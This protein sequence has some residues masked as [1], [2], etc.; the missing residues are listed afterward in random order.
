MPDLREVTWVKT[1]SKELQESAK[2]KWG[3]LAHI[4]E[5][6]FPSLIPLAFFRQKILSYS[7][8][9]AQQA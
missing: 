2:D 3:F 1:S 5:L 9:L 6:L 8:L 7:S 4:L